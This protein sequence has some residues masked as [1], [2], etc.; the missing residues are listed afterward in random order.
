ML[1]VDFEA[2]VQENRFTVKPNVDPAIDESKG[3][4]HLFVEALSDLCMLVEL[5]QA[6][7]CAPAREK[8]DGGTVR[9][10]DGRCSKRT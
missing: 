3:S 1:Q 8:E 6:P 5:T 10:P 9:L 7:L 2:T 4:L